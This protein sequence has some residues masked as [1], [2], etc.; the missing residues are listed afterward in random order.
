MAKKKSIKELISEPSWAEYFTGDLKPQ[1]DLHRYDDSRGNRFYWFIDDKGEVRI[2]AGVTSVLGLVSTE[3]RAIDQWKQDNE[4]WKQLLDASSE[5]GTL[6]H[7]IFADVILGKGVDSTKLAQMQTI[8]HENG[9]SWDMA[10]KDILSFLKFHEDVQLKPIIIEGMLL[11]HDKEKDEYL[12]MTIDLLATL[13]ITTK[14]KKEVIV[15]KY[16]RG[17]KTGQD[18]TETVIE[19]VKTGKTVLIDFKSNFFEKDRKTFY[20]AHKMQLIAGAKAVKQN[21]GITVDAIYNFAPGNTWR[22]NPDYTFKEHEVTDNDLAIW[23]AYWE[24][25]L[26]KGL[27]RPSGKIFVIGDFKNSTDYKLLSYEEYVKQV[28]IVPPVVAND[29]KTLISEA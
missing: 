1:F 17:E 22:T 10:S 18:K 14:V 5:Y 23:D 26:V 13:T 2:A 7:G 28:L 9:S 20:E 8:A 29:V 3:R 12:A 21:F 27:N 24:L 25:A 11:W 15:G 6:L 16:A 4:N 19:E